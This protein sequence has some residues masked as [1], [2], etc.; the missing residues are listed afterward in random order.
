MD[1]LE[2]QK[3]IVGMQAISD[4]DESAHCAEDQLYYDFVEYLA[5]NGSPHA[6]IRKMARALIKVRD[7]EFARWHA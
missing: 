3:R 4:D 5:A 2:I 6:G 1:T 7:I